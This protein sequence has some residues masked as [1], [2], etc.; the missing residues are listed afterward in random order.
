MSSIINGLALPWWE[1]AVRGVAVYLILLLLMRVS[2]KRSFGE[3]SA[4]D[5]IVLVLVGGTLRT[6]I[7]GADTSFLGALIAVTGILATDKFLAIIC[8]KYPVVNRIVEGKATF[9]VRRGKHVPGALKRCN[10]PLAAFDRAL[11]SAG[12]EDINDCDNARL[13]PNG[14]ITVTSDR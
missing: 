3:M 7:I 1:F 8:T 11:H 12:R 5:V 4:F 9:L 2:G 10:I 14:R 6:S 13:E